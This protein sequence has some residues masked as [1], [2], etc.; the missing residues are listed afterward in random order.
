MQIVIKLLLKLINSFEDKNES[1]N[2]LWHINF[3]KIVPKQ[4][5]ENN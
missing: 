3:R 5:K 2:I 4:G 1:A